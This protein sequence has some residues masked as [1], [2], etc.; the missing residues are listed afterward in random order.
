MGSTPKLLYLWP[1]VNQPRIACCVTGWALQVEAVLEQ[2]AAAAQAAGQGPTPPPGHHQ[3]DKAGDDASEAGR[4]L[5]EV[6]QP[7]GLAA[8]LAEQGAALAALQALVTGLQGQGSEAAAQAAAALQEVCCMVGEGQGSCPAC[9][10]GVAGPVNVSL[11][12]AALQQGHRV[13][14]SP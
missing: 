9:S 4:Q 10:G 7:R 13:P 12:V 14:S 3:P 1:L 5:A 6:A 11:S 2:L 8:A